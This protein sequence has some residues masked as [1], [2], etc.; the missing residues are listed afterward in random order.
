MDFLTTIRTRRSI[1][2]F[3]DEK[4]TDEILNNCIECGMYA[5]SAGNE[6]P[7]H[8]IM[9][10]DKE[11]LT[12]IPTVHQYAEMMFEAAAG[13]VVCFDPSLEKHDQMSVQDCAAATQNILLAAHAQGLGACWL[14]IYPRQKRMEGFR[15]LFHIPENIIPFAAIAI[16]KPAEEKPDVNRYRSDRIHRETW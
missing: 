12:K 5:P 10:K 3:S 11:L 14:G 15:S 9:I 7:W 2:A 6:Q 16:G 13:I 8:F 4:I 1:R